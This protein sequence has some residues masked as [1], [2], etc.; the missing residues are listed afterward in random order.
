MPKLSKVSC[1]YGAPMGRPGAHPGDDPHCV[2]RVS[3]V[4][5]DAGGYDSGGAYWGHGEPLWYASGVDVFG[6]A[7]SAIE[8]FARAPSK[9]AAVALWRDQ[10]PN[11]RV[12]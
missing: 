8:D 3:R 9:T 11:A 5:L 12:W 2:I 4:R 6:D 7:R 10:W 1:K